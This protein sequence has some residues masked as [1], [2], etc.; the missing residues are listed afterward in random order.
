MCGYQNDDLMV[1]LPFL[2]WSDVWLSPSLLLMAF[3]LFY[4]YFLR[5]VINIKTVS[6]S[7]INNFCSCPDVTGRNS[8]FFLSFYSCSWQFRTS[9]GGRMMLFCSSHA[10]FS[11]GM[12]SFTWCWSKESHTYIHMPS[13]KL[14]LRWWSLSDGTWS[15]LLCHLMWIT[16]LFFL[17]LREKE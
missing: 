3:S 1:S 5:D 15:C 13:L 7:D 11:H 14:F 2:L 8:P 10:L 17:F 12:I 6:P 4:C 9:G 16:N